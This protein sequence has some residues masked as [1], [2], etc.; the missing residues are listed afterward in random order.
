MGKM[1]LIAE[2]LDILQQ[3]YVARETLFVRGEVSAAVIWARVM[4]I[5]FLGAW[6]RRLKL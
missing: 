1:E 6:K 5:A 4:D 3:M 2:F